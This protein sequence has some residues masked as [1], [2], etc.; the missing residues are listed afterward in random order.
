[1][2]KQPISTGDDTAKPGTVVAA[3]GRSCVVE[4]EDG[5]G[6]S[7]SLKCHLRGRN[8]K[9]VCGDQVAWKQ[10]DAG[11]GVV[12]R[13]EPR[14]NHFPRVLPNGKVKIVAANLDW[15]LVTV[16]P[17]P[18]PTRDLINR[19]LVASHWVGV[20]V[21][22][23]LNK[24]DLI[25]DDSWPRW[26]KLERT[27]HDLGYRFLT[28]CAKVAGGVEP[29]LELLGTGRGIL[30]G[31]SGVGKSSL[32]NELVPQAK[33]A[34]AALSKATHKGTHTTT[35]STLHHLPR[36]GELIDS[37]GVWEYGI[38]NM[39]SQD[40]ALGFRE[41]EPFLGGCRF[42]DC[43]HLHEPGCA[44]DKAVHSGEISPERYASYQRIAQA[45]GTPKG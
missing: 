20:N 43:T 18:E 27:Y 11:N 25:D 7:S 19:Y 16:A 22:I 32:T 13:V 1:M 29:I 21:G 23:V 35:S 9:P 34:I 6:T 30:V 28:V 26:R 17:K 12:E 3:Y 40:V 44:I 45:S 37:P 5:S 14:K 33:L 38:W 4:H 2:A 41:F 24:T 31:Q 36:G 42:A 15:I 10:V 8:L 39:S